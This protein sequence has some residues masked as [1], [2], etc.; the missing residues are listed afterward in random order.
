MP[1]ASEIIKIAIAIAVG[2]NGATHG[3]TRLL[4]YSLALTK[5]RKTHSHSKFDK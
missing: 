5:Q 3:R 1:L 2:G 4:L